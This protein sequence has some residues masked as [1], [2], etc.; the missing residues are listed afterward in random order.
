M[1]LADADDSLTEE[2]TMST[3]TGSHMTS[4]DVGSSNRERL[5]FHSFVFS[6]KFGFNRQT[7]CLEMQPSIT[8]F[9]AVMQS[10]VDGILEVMCNQAHSM[11]SFSML[12]EN[13]RPGSAPPSVGTSGGSQADYSARS[14]VSSIMSDF[15]SAK[16]EEGRD[17]NEMTMSFDQAK[18]HKTIQDASGNV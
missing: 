12:S 5:E 15:D 17:E 1:S 13:K 14:S 7:C 9:Q 18:K 11:H 16:G 10:S 4:K 8:K 2:E 6:A 3:A